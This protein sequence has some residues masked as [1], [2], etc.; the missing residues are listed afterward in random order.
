MWFL[1]L[2]CF[3]NAHTELYSLIPVGHVI[4]LGCTVMHGWRVQCQVIYVRTGSAFLWLWNALGL[5]SRCHFLFSLSKS[6]NGWGDCSALTTE[7]TGTLCFYAA[8][9]YL[10]R[11]DARHKL[12]MVAWIACHATVVRLL[13]RR[14]TQARSIRYIKAFAVRN[15]I[16]IWKI[17]L[18]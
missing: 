15:K 6:W 2:F 4:A 8:R 10:K 13:V 16:P 5:G 1:F 17:T 11:D 3:L 12:I 14:A 7:D 18:N 9:L